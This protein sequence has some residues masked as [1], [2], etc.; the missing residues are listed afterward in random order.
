MSR[1]K[2]G[3]QQ[4]ILRVAH[5]GDVDR[6]LFAAIE[7]FQKRTLALAGIGQGARL[8]RRGIENARVLGGPVEFVFG[9]LIRPG[10]LAAVHVYFPD[11]WWK[12]KHRRRRVFT[13]E[14]VD[15]AAELLEP[16]GRLHSWTDVEEYFE[17]IAGLMDHHPE[18][19]TLPRPEEREP[20][21]DLDYLTSFE[22]KRRKA[23]A[24]VWR[25]EWRRR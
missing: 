8:K 16:G 10:S 20:E 23:G 6:H 2:A 21:H 9:K 7:R 11:P 4:R 14:L 19:E 12:R 1:F 5:G 18:F 22:R 13:D 17:V 3:Q 24:S 15:Q 25:G